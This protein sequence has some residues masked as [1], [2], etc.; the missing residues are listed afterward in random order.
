LRI[1]SAADF[2]R[3]VLNLTANIR[4]HARILVDVQV[5]TFPPSLS[6]VRSHHGGAPGTVAVKV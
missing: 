3:G 6:P 2:N 5:T 1:V 4:S